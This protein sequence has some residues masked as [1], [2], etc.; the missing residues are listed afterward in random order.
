MAQPRDQKPRRDQ[1]QGGSD[2]A[3]G[4]RPQLNRGMDRR[5]AHV[6]YLE[7]R[8]GGG[9]KPTAEA[10][11]RAAKQWQNLPG[12]VGSPPAPRLTSREAA[13]DTPPA[14]DG[15]DQGRGQ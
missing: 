4:E 9:A 6:E 5:Q 13:E 8:L 3:G 14:D 15:G 2:D 1:D 7:R 10:Y 11:A 12:A